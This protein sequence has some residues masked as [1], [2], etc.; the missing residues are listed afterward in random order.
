MNI[1]FRIRMQDIVQYESPVLFGSRCHI[2]IRSGHRRICLRIIRL[3]LC[4][5]VPEKT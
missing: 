2:I 1:S 5:P 3:L 4:V